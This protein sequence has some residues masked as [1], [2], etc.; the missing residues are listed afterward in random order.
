MKEI[1]FVSAQPD[2]PYFIWQIKLY[3][4]NFI[5]KGIDP[6]QI[7]VVL[8]LVLGKTEPSKGAKEL[9]NLGINTHFFIDN[10]VKKHYIPSIKPY[11]ISKWIQSNPDY[12]KIFFLHDA[13]IMFRELPKFDRLLNDEVS[14]LSDTIG[15]I[16]YDYIMDC[17]K[18]YESKHPNSE[19]G[20]LLGE[21]TEI[22]GIDVETIKENQENS[23]GG[24]YLIKNTTCEFWDKIYR[25]S[26]T[27]YDKMLDYQNRFPINPG[28]IQFWTAE[29]WSLLWNLWLYGIE[30]KITNEFDFSWATDDINKYNTTPILH[31]AGVTQ[32]LKTTKF[33]KGDYINIDPIE[34]LRKTPNVFDYIDSNSSTIKYIENMKSYL[35]KSNI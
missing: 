32:D 3:V 10:R 20:Q 26:T 6:N 29:M 33:F 27:L 18:R 15:Y 1:L 12:G 24:Q 31:M 22:I 4:N 7:H 9:V 16:G 28:Q 14:Y 21:M 5:D 13:D 25:D 11:L 30:T 34:E 2:V 35:Q 19:N 17:C 23:G 8:G